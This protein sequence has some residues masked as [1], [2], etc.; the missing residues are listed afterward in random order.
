MARRVLA[1]GLLLLLLLPN[2]CAPRVA[3]VSSP[4]PA[5]TTASAASPFAPVASTV[6]TLLGTTTSST[7]ATATLGTSTAFASPTA[8]PAPV[9]PIGT[10]T[11]DQSLALVQQT[12]T[13]LLTTFVQH[14]NSQLLLIL[15]WS[16]AQDEAGREGAHASIAAPDLTGQPAQDLAA[17]SSQ[18]LALVG[19]LAGDH[20]PIAFAAAGAMARSAYNDHTAFLNPAQL[21][22]RKAHFI[23]RSTTVGL[24]LQIVPGQAA[25]LV[26]A[27]YPDSPA[28]RAGVKPGDEIVT[29][30][31]KT[32]AG[33]SL[34]QANAAIAVAAGT[35][36]T[37]GLKRPDGQAFH[38]T[39]M[40][41][42]VPIPVLQS[43]VLAGG[44][45]Y[46]HLYSF[47]YAD[48]VLPGG[49]TVLQELDADLETC[50][51]AQ[52]K[53][54]VLD[55]RDNSGGYDVPRF[56]ARFIADGVVLT[57]RDRL[58]A[59]HD[60]PPVGRLFPE[61]LPLAVVINGRSASASEIFAAAVQDLHRGVVVGTPSAGLVEGSLFDPLPFGAALQVAVFDALRTSN[62]QS[63]DHTGVTPDVLV[64]A[65]PTALQLAAGSDPQIARAMQ[66]VLAAPHA[67]SP[68]PMPTEA[69]GALLSRS[70]LESQLGP[71][72]APESAAPGRSASEQAVNTVI[73]T[74]NGYST[75]SPGS[76]DLQQS[77]ARATPRLPRSADPPLPRRPNVRPR[78]LSL[79]QP[80]RRPRRS[81]AGLSGWGSA[82]SP[83]D[84]PHHPPDPSW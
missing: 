59:V 37:L 24:G 69:P 18:Y 55:L 21:L 12:Y 15:A 47:P 7:A 62:G 74:L 45:C 13:L 82:E 1:G 32:I 65:A 78:R 19:G 68:T 75:F 56:A 8:T 77:R 16:A 53:G 58:Q 29:I 80:I 76:P 39:A 67:A 23:G 48:Q 60:L 11:A 83:R 20:A 84:H 22:Q 73:D 63:L 31:G 42:P 79:R 81:G 35:T 57:A 2:A 61:Q 51:Q 4:T 5:L 34:V 44:V 26:G 14:L 25:M 28:E 27:V 64:D 17:F 70:A 40:S 10:P 50:R 9:P 72:I 38:V 30:G 49:K 46:L 52:V 71:L 6:A 33:L 36:I 54:W 66:I 41:A 3:S 43:R